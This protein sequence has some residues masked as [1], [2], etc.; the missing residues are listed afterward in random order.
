MAGLKSYRMGEDI[1]RIISAKMK[2]LKDPR[3]S[4]ALM[5]TIV[6]CEVSSDGSYCKVYVSSLEGIEQAKAATEAFERA[7]GIFKREISNVLHLR[8]CPELKFCADD[9]IEYGAKINELLKDE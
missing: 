1:K 8:K 7:K 9:S 4:G 5:L 3:I 2:D 6:R